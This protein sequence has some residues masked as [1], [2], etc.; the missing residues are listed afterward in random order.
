MAIFIV[1][2]SP[3]QQIIVLL[4]IHDDNNCIIAVPFGKSSFIIKPT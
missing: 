3:D 1:R 2:Y 4:I